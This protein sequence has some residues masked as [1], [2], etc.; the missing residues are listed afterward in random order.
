ML[1]FPI[2]HSILLFRKIHSILEREYVLCKSL[3]Y[4]PDFWAF[5]SAGE[6]LANLH[7]NYEES[8]GYPLKWEKTG[9]RVDFRVEKM[10]LKGKRKVSAPS[11]PPPKIGEEP[12]RVDS[13][14]RN[15]QS[16][17]DF[18]ESE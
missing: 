17:T 7:L 14:K 11:Q 2:V 1:L 13:S 5:S 10:R 8:K 15:N 9:E 3:P 18:G 4:A 12:S 6:K 16:L